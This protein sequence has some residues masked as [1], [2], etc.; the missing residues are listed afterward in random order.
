MPNKFKFI[1]CAFI[2][3]LNDNNIRYS[4]LRGYE[5]LPDN[6]SNDVDFGIHPEDKKQFFEAVN[7]FLINQDGKVVLRSTRFEVLKTTFEFQNLSLDFDFW[8]DFNFAGLKYME[9]TQMVTHHSSYNNINVLTV[10]DEL[11]L[12]F[13]KELLHNNKIRPDKIEVLKDRLLR[14]DSNK[15]A[16]FFKPHLKRQFLVAIE[17]R[18]FELRHLSTITKRYLIKYNISRL[19]IIT[20]SFNVFKFIFYRLFPYFNPLTRE[21]RTLNK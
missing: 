17:K 13:L 12:S 8:F 19:G 15:I 11:T 21:I 14:S 3:S 18:D 1:F 5:N 6:F 2:S 7:N 4:I 9:I 16:V 10:E 20:S